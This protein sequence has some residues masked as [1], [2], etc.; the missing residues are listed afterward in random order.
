MATA[1]GNVRIAIKIID[2]SD[3]DEALLIA[4]SKLKVR[5]PPFFPPREQ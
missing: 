2:W 4:N 1:P 3:V 5:T